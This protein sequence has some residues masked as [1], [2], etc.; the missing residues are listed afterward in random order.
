[1]DVPMR[2]KPAHLYPLFALRIDKEMEAK[3]K[4]LRDLGVDVPTLA[5]SAINECFDQVLRELA[6]KRAG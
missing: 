3:K 2:K 1:M 5:K 6:R 4:K